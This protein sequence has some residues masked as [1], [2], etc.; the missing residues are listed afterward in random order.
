MKTNKLFKTAL[1]LVALFGGASAS[2]ADPAVTFSI[3]QAI[4]EYILIGQDKQG[5]NGQTADGVTLTSCKVDGNGTCYTIGS[6]GSSTVIQFK[7]TATAGNYVFSFKSGTKDNNTSTLALVLAKEGESGTDIGTATINSTGSWDPVTPHNYVLNNLE[8]DVTYTLTMTMALTGSGSNGGNFANFCFHSTNQL[9]LPFESTASNLDLS[10]NSILNNA[11]LASIHEANYI[12]RAGGYISDII[13]Y[14]KTA[15]RYRLSFNIS[16]Y[17]QTSKLKITIKSFDG[18]TTDIDEQ[19]IDITAAGTYSVLLGSDLTAGL[20]KIKFDFLDDDASGDDYLYNLVNVNFATDEIPHMGTTTTYLDFSTGSLSTSSSP[21]Y[22]SGNHNLMTYI[23]DG[24]V[25]DN[26]YVV[27]NEDNAYLSMQ[28][29]IA[30]ANSGKGYVKLTVTDM[31]TSTTEINQ[32]SLAIDGNGT[33]TLKLS[34]KLSKGIKKIRLDFD[35]GTI[36]TSYLFNLSNL[37]FYK[38]SLNDAYDYTP[39]AATEVDIV[40]TRTLSADKWSTIMLPF[41]RTAEQLQSDLGVTTVTLAAFTSFSDNTLNFSPASS[42]TANTPYMIKVSED[43]SG[44]KTINGVN[45][46]TTGNQYVDQNGVRFQGVYASTTMA[47]GD[48]FFSNN[49]LYKATS[50]KS[51]KP[52][53]AYFKDVPAGARLMFFDETTGISEVMGNTEKASG[54]YY[55]LQGRRIAQPQKGLY[56]VNGKKVFVK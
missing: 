29:A 20:K 25:A 3:P 33:Y 38:R 48:Y 5:Q 21:R 31:V 17:K 45:I 34:N 4:G 15:G 49:K 32:E 37:T 43:V 1:L 41:E 50:T 22:D 10:Y 13:S 36:T 39:V 40:L 53:R 52:F 30:N 18:L 54:N 55:D 28:V 14:V 16:A 19:T 26:F 27:N 44:A 8:A 56:I 11:K 35:K 42:I 9:A 2:W 12:S 47:V 51:I 24:G 23:A 7:F 6:T 46:V